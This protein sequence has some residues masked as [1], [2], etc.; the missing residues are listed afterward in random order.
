MMY[1]QL[2]FTANLAFRKV[3]ICAI[4]LRSDLGVFQPLDK[5]TPAAKQVFLLLQDQCVF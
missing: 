1:E 4:F 3:P 5:K 2:Y